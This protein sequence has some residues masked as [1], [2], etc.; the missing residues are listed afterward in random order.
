[1]RGRSKVYTLDLKKNDHM[2]R[3]HMWFHCCVNVA[4]DQFLLK[5]SSFEWK[6]YLKLRDRFTN[7]NPKKSRESQK[8][9]AIPNRLNLRYSNKKTMLCSKAVSQNFR[10]NGE[11]GRIRYLPEWK[12]PAGVPPKKMVRFLYKQV[13]MSRFAWQS[14]QSKILKKKTHLSQPPGFA[15][16]FFCRL[17]TSTKISLLPISRGCGFFSIT[18]HAGVHAVRFHWHDQRR[19]PPPSYQQ[20]ILYIC[21]PSFDTWLHLLKLL[22]HRRP[23]AID[24]WKDTRK[25]QKKQQSVWEVDV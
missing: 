14:R 1:M 20:Q 3:F 18:S 12:A 7:R 16:S 17:P 6:K 9:Q 8:N 15:L 4:C 5:P 10:T 21:V 22:V 24:T 11:V 19:P 2:L 23:V 13:N 25:P